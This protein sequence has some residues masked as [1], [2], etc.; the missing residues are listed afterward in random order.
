MLHRD[1][2]ILPQPPRRR[3][4]MHAGACGR[5]HGDRAPC[6]VLRGVEWSPTAT[7]FVTRQIT[8]DPTTPGG[9]GPQ[10]GLAT[11]SQKRRSFEIA[12]PLESFGGFESRVNYCVETY[13][14]IACPDCD[15][16]L[17]Q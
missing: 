17:T 13:A 2:S 7:T 5:R 6:G 8:L 9:W 1:T 3:C 4:A 16:G 15:G 12:I 11:F 14:T 10:V